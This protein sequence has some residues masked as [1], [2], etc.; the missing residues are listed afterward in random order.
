[1]T[2]RLFIAI[3]F[4]EELKQ[5]LLGAV[6]SL[7]AQSEYANFTHPENLHLTLAF[8]GETDRVNDV[9]KAL[10]GIAVPHFPLARGEAGHFGKLYYAGIERSPQLLTLADDLSGRLTAAGFQIDKREFRPHVTLARE[11]VPRGRVSLEL[12][13]RSMEVRKLSLMRSER[14]NGRLTY[15]EI[16]A[17]SLI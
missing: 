17:K 7:R 6:D 10:E 15:T 5:A 12:P 11:L 8:I 13:L 3:L 2:M 14:L 16:F 1:M 9:K 4:S